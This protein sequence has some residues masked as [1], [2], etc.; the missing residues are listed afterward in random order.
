MEGENEDECMNSSLVNNLLTTMIIDNIATNT[1]LGHY[2]PSQKLELDWMQ[3][4]GN[5]VGCFLPW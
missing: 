4:T 2:R 1:V 3:K 5:L